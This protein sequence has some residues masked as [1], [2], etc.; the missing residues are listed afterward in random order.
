MSTPLS[1]VSLWPIAVRVSAYVLLRTELPLRSPPRAAHVTTSSPIRQQI[2]AGVEFDF[3]QRE[4]VRHRRDP[5]VFDDFGLDNPAALVSGFYR[6]YLCRLAVNDRDDVL[7]GKLGRF[8]C[9]H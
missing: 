6:G 2:S 7:R 4:Y 1:R 5:P 3:V 8:E 9:M